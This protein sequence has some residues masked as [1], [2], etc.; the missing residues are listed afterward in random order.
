MLPARLLTIP[1]HMTKRSR[2]QPLT[3]P[4]PEPTDPQPAAGDGENGGSANSLTAE[5]AGT[6]RRF[7]DA[8]ANEQRPITTR[9]AY[10]ADLEHFA[11]E[12]GPQSLLAVTKDDVSSWLANNTRM[13]PE[14][15]AR[16]RSWTAKTRNR[17]LAALKAFYRWATDPDQALMPRSPA[18]N[19]RTLKV[20]RTDPVRLTERDL[21]KLFNYLDQQ[22]AL[23]DERHSR[24]FLLDLATLRLCYHLGLRISEALT[25]RF[26]HRTRNTRG[27]GV[28]D[29]DFLWEFRTKGDN[30]REDLIAGV[31][32]VDLERWLR[33]RATIAAKPGASDYVFLHPWTGRR[34]TRKRAWERLNKAGE[35]VGLAEEV[36]E[37]LSPHKLRHAVAYHSLEAGESVTAV[38]ALLGHANVSTTSIYIQDDRQARLEMIRRRSR[39]IRG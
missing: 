34:V 4:S 8:L 31:V 2:T 17:K 10:R 21:G 9:S 38:Q 13:R 15:P 35:A 22:I 11:S 6:I 33:V 24:L 16:G 28:Q 14:D 39:D 7:L 30:I 20:P 23:R 32:R 12:L 18:E 37:V 29:G 3:A 27:S 36:R 1:L 5:N 19:V 25:M 26:S